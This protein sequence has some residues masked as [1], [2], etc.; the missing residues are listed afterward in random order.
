M[1]TLQFLALTYPFTYFLIL[2]G[3]ILLMVIN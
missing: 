1:I 2:D 3:S